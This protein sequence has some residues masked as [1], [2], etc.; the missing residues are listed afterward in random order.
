MN[1]KGGCWER[2][3][4]T[5]GDA[6]VVSERTPGLVAVENLQCWHSWE[7]SLGVLIWSEEGN[8]KPSAPHIPSACRGCKTHSGAAL[9]WHR[10]PGTIPWVT[11][12]LEH[13]YHFKDMMPIPALQRRSSWKAVDLWIG[14]DE[15]PM[16]CAGRVPGWIDTHVHKLC[17][18]KR[19]AGSR[20]SAWNDGRKK[21][22]ANCSSWHY[23][24]SVKWRES[25]R[26][27]KHATASFNGRAVA[28]SSPQPKYTAFYRPSVN[29]DCHYPIS[30]A[31]VLQ[32]HQWLLETSFLKCP[33]NRTQSTMWL[34]VTALPS[35]HGSPVHSVFFYRSL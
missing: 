13:G 3:L 22:T 31:T 5:V 8:Q 2:K 10:E 19:Q 4:R 15:T 12:A 1:R 33:W 28:S 29:Y 26:K 21:K 14:C 20:F 23:L 7:K 32:K 25:L 16:E 18:R 11:S 24:P 17:L 35:P 6:L 27:M 30:L 34:L 9:A